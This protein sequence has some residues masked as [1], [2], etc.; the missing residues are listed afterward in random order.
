MNI[1]NSV[2]TIGA[3]ALGLV[4]GMIILLVLQARSSTQINK[5][6]FPA[7][8]FTIKK[9]ENEA[10]AIIE[11]AQEQAREIVANAELESRTMLVGRTEESSKDYEAYSKSLETLKENLVNTLTKTVEDTHNRSQEISDTFVRHLENQDHEMQKKIQGLATQLDEIPERLRGQS[12][13]IMEGLQERIARA[14]E[15]LEHALISSH[16]THTE[17]IREHLH[18]G[19]EIAERDIEEYRKG[20]K[21][22]IDSHIEVLV[23]DVV[24]VALQKELTRA[25]HAD[26][27]H[28]ALEEARS[29]GAL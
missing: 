3:I 7:Y 26:L 28:S 1:F 13:L 14:G 8:E 22:L 2:E 19:F 5:L 20:R 17:A 10:N 21:A 12:G 6:T 11:K 25:D 18:K 16:D 27:V 4:I 24:R 15:Q 9:A 23:K 29:S